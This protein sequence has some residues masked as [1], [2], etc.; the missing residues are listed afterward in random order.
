[1]QVTLEFFK[2]HFYFVHIPLNEKQYEST[3]KYY[4]NKALVCKLYGG[5][6]LLATA[7]INFMN[8]NG[9]TFSL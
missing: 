8:C 5:F 6:T 2:A 9:M 4:R 1:M 3:G 7:S